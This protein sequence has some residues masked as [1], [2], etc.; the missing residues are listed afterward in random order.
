MARIKKVGLG[1]IGM[2]AN[3]F[4]SEEVLPNEFSE[5]KT[6]RRSHIDDFMM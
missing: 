2:M 1:I 6:E 5:L 3:M 4:K